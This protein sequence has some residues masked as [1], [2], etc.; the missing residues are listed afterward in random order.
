[1]SHDE[2][3]TLVAELNHH[4]YLYY[5]CDT[6]VISDSEYDIMFRKL[7]NYETD[8]PSMVSADSPTQRV[9]DKLSS[10]LEKVERKLKMYSL[11]NIFTFEELRDW[12]TASI[13]YPVN[14]VV[15][16]K[17]DG[18]A[19][20]A[21]FDS[22]GN[23]GM[24]LTRGDGL[25]G[26]DVTANYRAVYHAMLKAPVEGVCYVRGEVVV[27]KAAFRVTNTI[28]QRNGG[29][30]YSNPRNL[31]AGTMRQLDP[32][33]VYS[34]GL[35][36]IPYEYLSVTGERIERSGIYITLNGESDILRVWEAIK[37]L[38]DIRPELPYDID[39]AVIK[40]EDPS[41][42]A[43]LGYTSRAPRFAMAFKFAEQQVVTR[44]LDVVP[45]VGRTGIITPRADL[46]P[47]A[48]AGVVVSSATVHNYDE[49]ARL[50][51]KEGC[52]VTLKRA[53]EVI[54]AIVG[55]VGDEGGNLI[56]P[57]T[58]CPCCSTELVTVGKKSGLY[59]PAGWE[60]DDQAILRIVHFASKGCMN[61]VGV[62]IST[63]KEW[64]ESR[65]IR[66]PV[67]LFRVAEMALPGKLFQKQRKAILDAKSV[68]LSRLIGSLGIPGVMESTASVI[69]QHYGS[70]E[71]FLHRSN[72]DQLVKLPDIGEI[73]A[74]NIV[75]FINTESWLCDLVKLG[76][77]PKMETVVKA[78]GPHSGEVIVI[79][80]TFKHPRSEIEL[81]LK[82]QGAVVKDAVSKNVTLL[83]AGDNAGS[84]LEK[85]KSLGIKVLGMD[86]V[87]T[88]MRI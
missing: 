80:G 5:C 25:V 64:Y 41:H 30:P 74:A 87:D 54:P 23:L 21:T 24:A 47:V 17:Y 15:E 11:D 55:V 88:L 42:I 84:K 40:I 26:E 3:Q 43:R 2:Y 32:K 72:F 12:L 39:G 48:I 63:V 8:N 69:A 6:S 13:S 60:C 19:I 38:G 70:F 73:T 71:Y 85:A 75:N 27:P 33:V 37:R 62:D 57:P 7:V 77:C 22:N 76:I 58:N 45:Q 83:L 35:Q 61:M 1:M 10:H 18:L 67:D 52:N 78:V 44:L 34:R 66:R 20:E 82:L 50:S 79:T 53:G 86:Y 49:V 81:R 4:A 36:F 51:L 28:I 65:L 46:E 31:A 14:V 56:E 68:S 16:P 9:G 29:K 59:C